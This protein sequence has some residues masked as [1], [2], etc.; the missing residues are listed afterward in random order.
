MR[1]LNEKKFLG[2]AVCCSPAVAYTCRHGRVKLTQRIPIQPIWLS[3]GSECT[4]RC[5]EMKTMPFIQSAWLK[6]NVQGRGKRRP[7]LAAAQVPAM[8]YWPLSTS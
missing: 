7:A 5:N 4:Q 3:S 6:A 1:C 2:G 8:K